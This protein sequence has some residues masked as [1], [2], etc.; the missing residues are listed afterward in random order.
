MAEIGS[1]FLFLFFFLFD[2]SITA[3]LLDVHLFYL[4]SVQGID[5]I[6]NIIFL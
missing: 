6:R 4:Y 1:R 2:C 3:D 5:I